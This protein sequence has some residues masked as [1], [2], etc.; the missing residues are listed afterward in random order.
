MYI[1]GL[2]S[3]F[4]IYKLFNECLN[5]VKVVEQHSYTCLVCVVKSSDN[6]NICNLGTHFD[7]QGLILVHVWKKESRM[8]KRKNEIDYHAKKRSNI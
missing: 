6:F 8:G 2:Q 4:N 5:Q 1:F 7:T 3:N